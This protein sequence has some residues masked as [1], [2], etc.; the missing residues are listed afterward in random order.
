MREV[1]PFGVVA[2]ASLTFCFLLPPGAVLHTGQTPVCGCLHVSIRP[3][4]AVGQ[5]DRLTF[6]SDLHPPPGFS[7]LPLH[8]GL[9]RLSE[10]RDLF[11]YLRK[12]L[13]F[14]GW[15]HFSD[16]TLGLR[17]PQMSGGLVTCHVVPANQRLAGCLPWN[18]R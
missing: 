4:V 10:V 2:H 11:L 1:C 14:D 5:Q 18:D 6:L 8:S 17:R 15:T 12:L 16:Q 7:R 3:R 9:S 13:P